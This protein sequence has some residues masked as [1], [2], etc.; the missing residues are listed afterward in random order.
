MDCQA[1]FHDLKYQDNLPASLWKENEWVFEWM[2][3]WVSKCLSELE[4]EWV[5]VWV[6]VCLSEWVFEW[7]G[8]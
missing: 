2:S 1:N 5:S 6:S 3:V 7:A 4:F 8:V